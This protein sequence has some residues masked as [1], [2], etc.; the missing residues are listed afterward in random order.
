[1]RPHTHVPP[2]A[3]LLIT[4]AVLCFATQ[5]ASIKYLTQR[6]PIPTL[7]WARYAVQ[8]LA[9]LIWLVPQMGVGLVRTPPPAPSARP[10]RAPAV[11]VGVLLH[12]AQVPAARRGDRDQ[13]FD[14]GARRDPRGGLSQGA[15]DAGAHCARH[16]G[17]RR[18]VPDRAT[19]FGD[20]PG[21]R[22]PVAR[23]RV[24]LRLL[25]DPDAQARERGLARAAVLSGARRHAG[26]DRDIAVVRHRDRDAVD[27]SRAHHRRRA[28]R[29]LRPFPVHPRV[30]ASAGVR[31]DAI[32]LCAPHL[33]DAHRVGGFRHVSRRMDARGDGGDRRQRPP[34]RVARTPAREGR[35]RRN[36]P[37][38]IER[39]RSR[40]RDPERSPRP[41]ICG[42]LGREARLVDRP[43]F[44][45]RRG[46]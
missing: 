41:V 15:D 17:H 22:A 23:R 1:M 18:D 39:L 43:A 8:A 3:I 46:P 19:G 5:D 27:R 10:R 20:V 33:G 38:S 9:L 24:L 36:P 44:S 35:C 45:G 16:R 7:V 40:S 11:L 14:A 4:G 21:R 6:H 31:A 29:H 13:L 32:Y 28:A 37:P 26:D 34:D 42:R 25:P 30:P 12:V 2:S